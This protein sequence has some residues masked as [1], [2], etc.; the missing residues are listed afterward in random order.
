MSQ[1]RVGTAA[2]TNGSAA[3]VGTGTSWASY[4]TAGSVFTVVGSTVP[5]VV[6]SV[7]DNTHL[8]LSSNYGGTTASGLSYTI[9]T[10]FTPNLGLPYVEQGDVETATILKRAMLL[11]DQDLATPGVTINATS[12]T[13][14]MPGL[15][16]KA[17][18][19]QTGKQFAFPQY[20]TI[21]SASAPGD[22]MAGQV[23]SYDPVAGN[24]MVTVSISAGSV[25][26]TDWQIS[27]S[28]SPGKGIN[29]IGAWNSTTAYLVGE[30]VLE[31][32]SAY[33]CTVANTAIQPPNAAYWSPIDLGI[34]YRGAWATA[35]AYNVNDVVKDAAGTQNVYICLTAHTSSVL[36]TD[37]T[38]GDWGLWVD[39]ATATT[40]AAT[41]TTQAGNAATSATAAANSATAAAGS[42]TSASGSASTATT[43]AGNAA[44]SATAAANSATAAAASAASI[45]SGPV[46]SVNGK[47]GVVTLAA[48][49]V[50]A[51]SGS[52]SSTGTNTGDQTNVT[53][54]AGTA[55]ALQTARNI[56]GVSFTGTADITVIAP[57]THA[58]VEK[59]V[60]V[61]ADEFPLIDSAASFALKKIT[62][63]DLKTAMP[64]GAGISV[65]GSGSTYVGLVSTF[66]INAPDSFTT[67]TASAALGTATL[68]GATIT[69]TAPATAGT[70]TLTITGGGSTKT[71]SITV[72]AAGINTPTNTSPA[73]AAT[74]QSSSVTLTASAFSWLGISTT[75]LNS[76]WQV[77]TDSGF[78]TVVASSMAD[79]VDLT[80]WTVTGLLAATTYYWRVRYRGANGAV[81]A[82]SAP[83]SFA[84]SATF[85]GL[86]GT[87]GAQGFGVGAYPTTLPSG[88]SA[89]TGSTDPTSANFGNYQFTDGS[90]EVFVPCFYYRFGNAAS[91]RYAT[92][93]ANAIDVVGVDTYAT[94]AAANTAG[95]AMHRAFKDGGANKSGFF[96]D[97]YLA[98]PNGTTSCKS[99]ALGVP[100]S[101]TSSAG[102][103][104]SSGMTGCS[105]ILADAVV[106]SRSRASG[107]FNCASVFMYSALA[108][109]SL[110]HAQAS[111]S[112]TYCAWY[113]AAGT[114]NF[115]KGCNN[116]SLADTNDATVT[117][118]TAGDSGASAKPKTGS[119]SPF[120][121]TTHNGQ[122]CGVADLNG[123]MY[124]VLLGITSPGANATDTTV[125]ADGNSYVLKT[126]VALSSL[127]G[128]YGGATDAWGTAANLATNYDAVTGIFPWG[129][130]TGWVYFGNGTNYVFSGATSGV[131]WQR[132]GCG[133]Q[134][135]TTGAS[136]AGTSQFG[137]DACYQYNGANLFAAGSAHWSYAAGAGVFCR[138]WVV[139]RSSNSVLFGFRAA[140]YGS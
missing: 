97:K 105:G 49:D 68:S 2:A 69:Y 62:L 111:T 59:P 40:A 127:T 67:Y 124:Q 72:G 78:V 42:A 108:L 77:A 57:A 89:L 48:S 122:A 41:A 11:I 54:N 81:S 75:Q 106:L 65:T 121:K 15:G 55:T 138:Y 8:T 30:G 47:T 18:V 126:T 87:P 83:F 33:L 109:L 80:S 86:I 118:T 136:A 95:Y 63:A 94:E 12:V 92:Y 29:W 46:T 76:D 21:A 71:I 50:G 1:Y 17:F 134:D 79:T 114:M 110:A 115:P 88:F 39:A 51:P 112:A 100:I 90:I 96:I 133:I 25:A 6:A 44:T 140:A 58:T 82:Y 32:S 4:V 53:G 66:T 56:D 14:V 119:G 26:H 130:T 139:C 74:G 3:I 99:V 116:G 93:G 13:S 64:S 22:Y 27:L 52:G 84:T 135:A 60:P 34:F 128:G 101:L 123:S 43:Q 10:S 28:G 120:A 107:T 125:E 24:L 23:T 103:T 70:D 31:N 132:T 129:S 137:N 19:T 7:T 20:L 91:P 5:Y 102:Y 113:D 16:A 98:S 117:Y 36:A 38:A 85:G 104:M 61:N 37:V 35:T 9:G 131:S 45:S 73:N